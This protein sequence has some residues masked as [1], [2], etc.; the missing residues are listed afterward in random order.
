MNLEDC[1]DMEEEEDTVDQ[2]QQGVSQMYNMFAG[3]RFVSKQKTV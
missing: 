1:V 3:P 2:S